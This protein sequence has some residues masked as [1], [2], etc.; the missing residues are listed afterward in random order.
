MGLFDSIFWQT[1]FIAGGPIGRPKDSDKANEF[2]EHNKLSAAEASKLFP[3]FRIE[4]QKWD[5]L[6]EKAK[7][8]LTKLGFRPEK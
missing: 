6:S 3:K 2:A 5:L 7:S 4:K 8:D 1:L